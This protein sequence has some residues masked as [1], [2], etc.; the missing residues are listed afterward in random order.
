VSVRQ[1]RAL[2]GLVLAAAALAA[3]PASAL[4][5]ITP[6]LALDQTAGT[7]AGSNPA[8]GFN[9]T[10][11]PNPLGDSVKDLSLGL[12][13]GLLANANINSGGCLASSTPSTSCQVG[14][15][16]ITAGGTPTPV[17]LYLVAPPKAGDVAGLALVV[18]TSV[19]PPASTAD[20]TLG[21]TGLDVA[22][23][24]LPNL[25]ISAMN[26]KVTNLRMPTSCPSP[27][28][29]VTLT[30]DSY[31]D[32]ASSKSTTAPLAVTGCAA[33]PYAPTIAASITRDAT[34]SGAG[35]DIA[36]T[37]AAN[38]SA[39]KSIVVNT[40]KGLSPNFTADAACLTV[41]PCQIGTATATSPLVPSAA[42]ANG[43]VTLGGSIASPTL[44]IAFPAPFAITLKG[45]VNL[46]SGAVT[47]AS[48]PDVPLTSLKLHITG[49]SGQKAFNITSCVP[50]NVSG[51]F[52]AQSGATHTTTV[53]AAFN[54]CPV[55]PT[56]TRSV[57]GLASGHPGLKF[58][59]TR[60]AGA[61]GIAVVAVGVPAGLSFAHSAFVSH[62]TCTTKGKKKC[63]RTTLIKGLGI[64]GARAKSVALKHGK[65]VITLNKPASS[66]T[67]TLSGPLVAESKALQTKVKKHR[68]KSLKFTLKITDANGTA[69]TV[70]VTVRPR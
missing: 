32:P 53:A 56:V 63:T 31:G 5:A 27:A 23:S 67:V 68:A 22:F 13:Q 44:T 36:I 34:D 7:T 6:S 43:T 33:L 29:N 59:V 16:T 1:R 49:P 28:A 64:S 11:S 35:L 19:A 37:Q 41:S 20:V 10:F 21:A 70:S 54:N 55:S 26:L 40:P 18:G 69:T 14:S 24:D 57:H 15:G 61:P 58:K 60:A 17:T 48:V 45:D 8:I 3:L 42:L 38:E 4:A 25:A 2:A 30:A 47:F 52:T 51:T 9:A 39:S 46:A 62:R 65:L 50:A 66:V 12:P